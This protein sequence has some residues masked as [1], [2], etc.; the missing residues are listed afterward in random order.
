MF[1]GFRSG[2]GS[3]MFERARDGV[4]FKRRRRR[5]RRGRRGGEGWG[6]CILWVVGEDWW[7]LGRDGSMWMDVV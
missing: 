1:I 6:R 3:R 4:R 7:L 2:S 5:A